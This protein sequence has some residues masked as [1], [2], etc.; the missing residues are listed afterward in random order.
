MNRTEAC[1]LIYASSFHLNW[2]LQIFI[3]LFPLII[4]DYIALK[5]KDKTMLK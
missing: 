5:M 1:F 2:Y 4:L 3:T